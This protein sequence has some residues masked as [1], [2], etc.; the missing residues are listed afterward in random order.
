M[1]EQIHP[2]LT[3]FW[4]SAKE[5]SQPKGNSWSNS[6]LARKGKWT[7]FIYFHVSWVFCLLL[8]FNNSITI[9]SSDS[10]PYSVYGREAEEWATS[11]EGVNSCP[12]PSTQACY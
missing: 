4:V 7:N 12:F 3:C 6:F 8:L 2:W 10:R 9:A 11:P 1:V 5:E